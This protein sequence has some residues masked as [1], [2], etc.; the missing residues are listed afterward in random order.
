MADVHWDLAAFAP[1]ATSCLV[2]HWPPAQG[3]P[4]QLDAAA[5][6]LRPNQGTDDLQFPSPSRRGCN[7][8]H[9]RDG[10]LGLSHIRFV[11]L[12]FSVEIVF[13][14][15]N[16]VFQSVSAKIQQAERGHVA[17]DVP[18]STAFDGALARRTYITRNIHF[19]NK[20]LNDES[21]TV[22]EDRFL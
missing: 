15:Q 2:R 1:E 16:S 5:L 11:R 10:P 8:Q 21:K 22:I 18:R 4:S 20:N 17:C 19:Y 13:F 6:W 14:S 9:P 3:C 12:L 7:H